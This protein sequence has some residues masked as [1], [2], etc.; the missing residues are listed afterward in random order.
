[1]D[2]EENEKGYIDGYDDDDDD[3][4][5]SS[6]SSNEEED[7]DNDDDDDDDDDINFLDDISFKKH[8]AMR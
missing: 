4:V 5:R 2:E 8:S 1:M 3:N 6:S 7:G